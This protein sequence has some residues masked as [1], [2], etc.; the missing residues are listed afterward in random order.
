VMAA[1]AGRRPQRLREREV[2]SVLGRLRDDLSRHQSARLHE[3]AALIDAE[4]RI[5]LDRALAVATPGGDDQR[6]QAAFRQVRRTVAAAAQSAGITFE[7]VPDTLK[8]APAHR[9]CWFEGEDPVVA[10]LEAM[11]AYGSARGRSPGPATAVPPRV[12]EVHPVPPVR[13]Q[14]SAASASADPRRAD[15]VADFVGM[16][17]RARPRWGSG[18]V[19]VTADGETPPGLALAGEGARLRTRAD[20]VVVLLSPASLAEWP[21]EV[22]ELSRRGKPVLLAALTA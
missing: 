10:E 1:T 13:I 19:E 15:A 5:P 20:L 7:L 18:A 3:L 14:V 2:L 9:W 21:G 6:R 22:A 11:S 4:G 16:L 17:R 8:I 12:S